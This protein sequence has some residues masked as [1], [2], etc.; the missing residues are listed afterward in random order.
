MLVC[1]FPSPLGVIFSLIWIKGTRQLTGHYRFP[2]PLGVIFSL[3]K[4]K[5]IFLK[6]IRIKF[7]SVSSRSYILSY[8]KTTSKYRNIFCCVSVSSRS[9]ILSYALGYTDVRTSTIG[10]PSPL[11]VIFSLIRIEIE[12]QSIKTSKFPSPLGVIFSL[13]I[14]ILV[15][16]RYQ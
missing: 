5:L 7:V 3:M 2:S 9:Y 11:G 8:S 10:F 6:S 16:L 4:I 13:I 15:S 14:K 1:L 12:Y